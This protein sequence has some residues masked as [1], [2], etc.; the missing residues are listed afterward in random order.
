MILDYEGGS[1]T[2]TK[3]FTRGRQEI[4]VRSKRFDDGSERLE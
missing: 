3:V 2:I 4:R 1:S